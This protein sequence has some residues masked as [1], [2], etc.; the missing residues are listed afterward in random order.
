MFSFIKISLRNETFIQL[1]SYRTY[2]YLFTNSIT[3]IQYSYKPLRFRFHSIN[4]KENRKK[5]GDA[6]IL[7]RRSIAKKKK[8]KKNIQTSS[9]L[10]MTPND[11][12]DRV[13]HESSGSY[14]T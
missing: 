7:S 2:Y 13:N 3:D 12:N 4:A 11:L 6:R 5:T 10:L 9:F 8:G 1:L 14:D